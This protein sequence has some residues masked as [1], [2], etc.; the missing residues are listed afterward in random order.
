M[1]TQH[2]GVLVVGLRVIFWRTRVQDREDVAVK[3]RFI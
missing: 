2:D 3:Q 1:F